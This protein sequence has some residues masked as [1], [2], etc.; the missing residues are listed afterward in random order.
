M[1]FTIAAGPYTL[2][3][4]LLFHPLS[5]LVEIVI[6]EKPDVL[7]MVR[8]IIV[9]KIDFSSVRSLMPH[10]R[11][12]SPDRSHNFPTRFSE[13]RSLLVYYVSWTIRHQQ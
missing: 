5:A 4:D 6:E 9:V 8:E 2:D 12:S 3:D 7:I 1:S 13:I 10:T 11:S